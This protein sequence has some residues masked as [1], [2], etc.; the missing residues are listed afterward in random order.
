MTA[1]HPFRVLV[2]DDDADTIA[3]LRDILELDGYEVE[4]AVTLTQMLV[5]KT[6]P[7]F[8]A[9]ILDRRLPDG[10]AEDILPRLKRLASD[11]AVVIVTGQSDLDG[12]IAA[13]RAG[14]RTTSSSRSTLI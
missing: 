10:K 4:T 5:L 13:I 9:I 8:P 1:E 12:A 3:N 6:L 14:P 11:A 7:T 2:V